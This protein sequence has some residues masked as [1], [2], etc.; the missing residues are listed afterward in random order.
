MSDR[1]TPPDGPEVDL[2]ALFAAAREAD[3]RAA[4]DDL[5]WPRARR[6]LR[7]RMA[8]STP[9]EHARAGA[10]LAGIEAASAAWVAAQ[11]ALHDG[12]L[13]VAEHL[14]LVA[15]AYGIGESPAYLATLYRHRGQEVLAVSW[16]AL[17][18]AE[19]HLE[20]DTLADLTTD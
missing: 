20:Y 9:A 18:C 11:A 15:A 6:R 7:A 19:G 17:A 1:H 8:A 3:E 10:E 12:D 13:A 5:D 4:A 2:D 14:L 16:A